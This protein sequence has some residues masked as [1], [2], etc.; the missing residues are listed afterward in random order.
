MACLC[1]SWHLVLWCGAM[2][3]IAWWGA[4]FIA[5]SDMERRLSWAD[6]PAP[7]D[8]ASYREIFLSIDFVGMGNRVEE[9]GALLVAAGVLALAVYRARAVFFAQ[10]EAEAKRDKVAATL[11]R[12]VPEAI[13]QKLVAD[14]DA[15]K[16]QERHGVALVMDVANF[17][18]FAAARPPA[19][20]IAA[21]NDFL[22]AAADRVADGG[23][24]VISFTGDGLLATFNTP[25]EIAEPER[26]ALATAGALMEES[27]RAGFNIRVGL[28]AGPMAAGSIG[29][30]RRQAFT[31]YGDTVNRAARLEALGKQ[32]G[33]AV[34]T[35]AAVA[36]N[37]PEPLKSQGA[38]SLRGLAGE[39]EVFALI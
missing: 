13:A 9:S 24:V 7:P 22:A 25:L 35:D 16:P 3:A 27:R 26:A 38:H 1:L 30:A 29:S 14:S 39:A 19:E 18:S 23:G 11:G 37:A 36:A 6:L 10:V 31:V 15:L 17:T 21:L 33:H 32:L 2:T 20:V 28:A 4:F 5:I 12:Y 8:L 34:L